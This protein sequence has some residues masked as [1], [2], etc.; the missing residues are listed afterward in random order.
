VPLPTPDKRSHLE[1]AMPGRQMLTDGTLD[2]RRHLR[3]TELLLA[4]A[5]GRDRQESCRESSSYPQKNWRQVHGDGPIDS[6]GL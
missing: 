6:I 1:D 3:A 4:G 2:L 5:R